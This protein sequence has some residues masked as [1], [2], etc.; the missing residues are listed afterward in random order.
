MA[1]PRAEELLTQMTTQIEPYHLTDQGN[2]QRF[3]DMHGGRARYCHLWGKWLLWDGQRWKQDDSAAVQ[4]LAEETIRAIY[5]E[6][7][8]I[9]DKEKREERIKLALSLEGLIRTRHMI[10]RAQSYISVSPDE[11][12]ADP[13]L[14]NVQNGT[15]N[16][17]TGE[18]L[19]HDPERL[20]TKISP[21]IYDP[22]ATCPRWL[23][24]ISLYTGAN[25]ELAVYLQKALG[26]CL[27]GNTDEHSM[28]F[29]YGLGANGKSTFMEMAL[30]MAGDYGMRTDVESLLVANARGQGATPHIAALKRIR[31]AVASEIPEGRRINESLVKDL[32]G[33]DTLVA[34]H[35]FS[36]PFTFKATHKLWLVGNYKPKVND[37]SLGFWRRMKLIP[38]TVTIPEDK[39]RPMGE[40]IGEFWFEASGILNWLIS[41][42]LSWKAHGLSMPEPVLQ[43]TNDYRTES[44][45]V[46]QYLEE[47]C[48]M[49]PDYTEDRAALYTSWKAWADSAGEQSAAKQSKRWFTQQLTRRGFEDQGHAHTQLS[50]LRLKSGNYG[51]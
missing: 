24:A 10:E 41:G 37:A 29:P 3:A 15:I 34:R 6:A 40:V 23:E 50:G 26:Y 13:T 19:P 30:Y 1:A 28:F 12:D 16:L 31:L 49:H 22:L 47:K 11:L 43:A 35:L 42:C 27:T 14:F 9:E 36:E 5:R 4:H 8:F 51:E 39:R 44:D 2:A 46:Q 25:A 21:V 20:I 7:S 33:G 18:L 32:T 48:E 17:I 45:L 38:F